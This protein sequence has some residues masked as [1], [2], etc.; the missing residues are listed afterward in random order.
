M[1]PSTEICMVVNDTQGDFFCKKSVVNLSS[2]GLLFQII[3]SRD[4]EKELNLLSP[5]T[6]C[7][8]IPLII[9]FFT[10]FSNVRFINL[11]LET[12]LNRVKLGSNL[13]AHIACLKKI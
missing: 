11:F 8:H 13:S 12:H 9:M 6:K 7:I 10:Y 4:G 1:A 5:Q 2:A 3:S